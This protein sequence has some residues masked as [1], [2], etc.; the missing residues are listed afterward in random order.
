V[1]VAIVGAGLMGKWHA[2]AATRAGASVRWVVDRDVARASA[3]AAR[4]GAA[5]MAS[6]EELFRRTTPD[7]VHICTPLQTH[8]ELARH[9]LAG[10][11]HA[12]VEKPL[13][14][15]LAD[16]QELL[17]LAKRGGRVLAPVHQ[18]LF[19]RGISQIRRHVPTGDVIAFR[20]IACSAGGE[21]GGLERDA[22]A[23]EILPHH[24]ALAADLT[25]RRMAEARWCAF[26][27]APG[28]LYVAG[29]VAGIHVSTVISLAARPTRNEVELLTRKA[30]A[31]ADLFHGFSWI[32]RRP[33]TRTQKAW[34]PFANG[35]HALY[36]ASSN[37][38]IRVGRFEQAYP[39]LRSLVTAFY[40]ACSG[41]AEWPI[42]AAL[43]EDESSARARIEVLV[44]QGGLVVTE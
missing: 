12:I 25:G 26:R 38:V 43:I 44:R 31:H 15:A 35:F 1:N 33:A 24:L 4:V 30:T 14:P 34:H 19:Q 17:A 23:M 5:A 3:L 20:S 18:M 11:A 29:D 2:N 8:F 40:A 41:R 27:S 39:G 10:G 16:T 36:G 28:E 13:A 21:A 32:D 7:A 22:V 6:V 42:P 9:A 37:L